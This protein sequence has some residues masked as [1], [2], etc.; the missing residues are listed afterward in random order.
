MSYRRDDFYEEDDDITTTVIQPLIHP[1]Q[2]HTESIDAEF[3]KS[4]QV[5]GK[6]F[7]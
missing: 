2:E 3:P 4:R 5:L 7:D 1:S 6:I